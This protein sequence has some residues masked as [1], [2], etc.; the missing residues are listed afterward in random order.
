MWRGGKL[1][2]V[3]ADT[4]EGLWNISGWIRHGAIS[5]GI[6]TALNSL[7]GQVYTFG[8]GPSA[9]TVTVSQNPIAKGSNTM[10]LGTVTDQSPGQKG[11]AAISDVDQAAW[12]EYLHMQKPKPA[13]AAGVQVKL[14]AVDPNGEPVDIGTVT[15]DSNGNF[16]LMWTPTLEGKYKIVA[17]FEGTISYGGSDATTYLGVGPAAPSASATP[18]PTT[19]PPTTPPVTAT[20]S[21]SPTVA[22]T[23]PG[24]LPT[25]TIIIAA[26]AVII[27]VAAAAAAVY[28]RRRK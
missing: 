9:T 4:G 5:D 12:M 26:A 7:D 23:P 20:L 25:E 28:M 2:V 1:W 10:I 27:I 11:T 18:P 14:T 24:A 22:P 17:T 19:P 13:N 8:K 15:S 6:L 16:G 3:N 21:P